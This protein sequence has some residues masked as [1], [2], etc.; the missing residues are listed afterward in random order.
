VNESRPALAPVM[1]RDCAEA[2]IEAV[3]AI[4]GHYVRSSLATFEEIAPSP[5]EMAQRRADLRA[6]GLP[7]LVASNKQGGIV[8]FAYAGYYRPRA[9]YRFTLEDSIYVAAEVTRHGIGHALLTRLVAQCAEAGFR[10]MVAVIGDSANAPSIGLHE[11][12]GFARIG[13]Q[14]AVGFKLGRWVDGVIM[15]RALGPGS[16]TAP[17]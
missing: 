3:A 2:D 4:Y 17:L 15:Q 12:A 16:A 1:I 13:V 6:A 14:P 9:A 5:M 10:Q 7:F 11:K 8:G